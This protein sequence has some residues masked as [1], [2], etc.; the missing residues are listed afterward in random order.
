MLRNREIRLSAR[1]RLKAMFLAPNASSGLSP[2]NVYDERDFRDVQAGLLT[3]VFPW[4]FLLDAFMEPVPQRVDIQQPQVV[5]EVDLYE[6]TPF[7]MGDRLGRQVDFLIHVFG[8]NRGERDDISCLIAD[9]F[10]GSL[11]IKT[12]SA[13]NTTGTV[14]ETAIVNPPI[15]RVKDIFTPRI[16]KS[17]QVELTTALLGWSSI[18]FSIMVKT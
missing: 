18:A 3:P 9:H 7:Q 16:E 2:F 15:F 4:V 17:S 13:T 10:G 8:K 5:I 6:S 11:D 12:Y 14:V 1:D